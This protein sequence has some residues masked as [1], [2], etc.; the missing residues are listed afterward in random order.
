LAEGEFTFAV[1]LL[2]WSCLPYVGGVALLKF[3]RFPHAAVGCIAVPLIADAFVYYQVFVRPTSSTAAVGL[4][5]MPLWN[6]VIL[7]PI[8]ATAGWFVGRQWAKKR[9]A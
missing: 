6:L 1:G 8:G 7:G 5:F 9:T 4:V 2:V 3:S